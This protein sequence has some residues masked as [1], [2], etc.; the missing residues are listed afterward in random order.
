VDRAWQIAQGTGV[1][2]VVNKTWCPRRP[3]QVM[4]QVRFAEIN[5]SNLKDFS[6]PCGPS[7]PQDLKSDGDWE[8]TSI[9]DGLLRVLLS[10]PNA[11]IEALINAS[12]TKGVL[13]SLAEPNLSPCLGKEASFL[14]GGEFPYRQSN[15]HFGRGASSEPGR[16]D[17][18]PEFVSGSSSLPTSPRASDPA[19]GGARS[20]HPRLC[21]TA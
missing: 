6:R 13:R 16:H 9:S 7:N 1:A 14:A 19:Q 8:G 15:H 20:V 18:V 21:Q 2:D 17:H 11:N 4:L 5:R 12:I 10:N 3:W